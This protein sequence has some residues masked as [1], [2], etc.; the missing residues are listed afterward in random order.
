MAGRRGRDA[1]LRAVLPALLFPGGASIA[2]RFGR[3]KLAGFWA[4]Q[5]AEGDGKMTAAP[6]GPAL[7]AT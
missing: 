2:C 4:V 6:R 5:P 7:T 1:L 3:S